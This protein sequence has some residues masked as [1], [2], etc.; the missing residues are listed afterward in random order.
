MKAVQKFYVFIALVTLLALGLT[1]T[2]SM[3]VD[4]T[5]IKAPV[6][7]IILL[8]YVAFMLY[9]VYTKRS[10][11]VMH[12]IGGMPNEAR[13]YMKAANLGKDLKTI[14]KNE[15]RMKQV[16][17]MGKELESE[18]TKKEMKAV[19][20]WQKI[21]KAGNTMKGESLDIMQH[22]KANKEKQRL[23]VGVLIGVVVVSCLIS[24]VK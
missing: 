9:Y 22:T 15:S 4:S 14:T 23:M 13:V 12:T 2:V 6:L 5:A 1:I 19:Q 7:S 11:A 18:F 24:L 8:A 20:E 17:S 3:L 21:S 16:K 10:V